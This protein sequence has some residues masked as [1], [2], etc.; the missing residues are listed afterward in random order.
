MSV[1]WNS[2]RFPVVSLRFSS[3]SSS[4]VS[5]LSS[6]SIR[7]AASAPYV[8]E[9]AKRQHYYLLISALMHKEKKPYKMYIHAVRAYGPAGE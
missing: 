5:S 9:I 4:A 1:T 3:S 7:F 8:P 2:L 6:A